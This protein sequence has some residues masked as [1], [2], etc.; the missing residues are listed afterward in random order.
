MGDIRFQWII[1]FPST[2]LTAMQSQ[3]NGKQLSMFSKKETILLI[4][5][6]LITAGLIGVGVWWFTRQS[7]VKLGNLHPNQSNQPTQSTAETFAQV[8]DVPKGLFN[9]GGSTTWAPIRKEKE[10]WFYFH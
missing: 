10:H 3:R 5:T 4:L 9:Y 2:P 7:G 1:R 6:L 8:Q